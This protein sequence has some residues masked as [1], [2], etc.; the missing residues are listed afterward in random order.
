M[1][2]DLKPSEVLRIVV[3][4]YVFGALLERQ[5]LSIPFNVFHMMD[6]CEGQFVRMWY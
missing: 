4:I 6:L 3:G 2:I 5:L 1:F